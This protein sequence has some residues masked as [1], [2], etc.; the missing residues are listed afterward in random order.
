[1][2]ISIIVPAYNEELFIEKCLLSVIHQEFVR[3]EFEVIVS[4]GGSSDKTN[5][6]AKKLADRIV[7][8]EKKGA[9]VQRNYGAKQAKGE[10][11]V[12]LDADTYLDSNFLI[13]I[14]EQFVDSNVVAVAGIA[15]PA[16]GKLPQRFV[17]RA[18][19]ILMRVLHFAKLSLFP[20]MCV[21]YRKKAFESAGGFR[22]DF[23]TLE[24]L[25][26]SKRVSKLGITKIAIRAHAFSSTRRIHKHLVTTVAYHI[27]CD[28]RY[29][30]TG[31]GP[32]RYPKV[33]ELHS[34]RDLW[35]SI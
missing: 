27:F 34:W 23:T 13:A 18:T 8:H 26:L 15:Y 22:E 10:I 28:V 12:F 7:V 1:M 35:K 33:E 11:L 2:F 32:R 4:D 29:L 24:D 9:S 5:T 17:Y 6:I 20:A 16:D 19:Y 30:L 21:A 14:K 31:K 25:D 3:S